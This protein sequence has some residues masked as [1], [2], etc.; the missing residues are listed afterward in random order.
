M[1]IQLIPDSSS[2]PLHQFRA[3]PLQLHLSIKVYYL[4]EVSSFNILREGDLY[5]LLKTLITLYLTG[6]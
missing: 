4:G 5:I 3:S 6:L 1:F 2:A